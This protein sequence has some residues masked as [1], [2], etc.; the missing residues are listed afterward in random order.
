MSDWL[1]QPRRDDASCTRAHARTRTRACACRPGRGTHSVGAAQDLEVK[2]WTRYKKKTATGMMHGD[3]TRVHFSH[4]VLTEMSD[5]RWCRT[6]SSEIANPARTASQRN[7]SNGM[8]QS[9]DTGIA[10][11][12]EYPQTQIICRK[13]TLAT[14]SPAKKSDVLAITGTASR[15]P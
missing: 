4:A 1:A 11:A 10:G 8:R 3:T 14:S 7:D 9:K 6:K 2:K 12:S 5:T 13:S 15:N